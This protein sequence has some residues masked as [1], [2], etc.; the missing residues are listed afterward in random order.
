MIGVSFDVSK[1]EGKNF[2]SVRMK[3]LLYQPGE[4]LVLPNADDSDENEPG[5]VKDVGD[6]RI[7]VSLQQVNAPRD[8]EEDGHSEEDDGEEVSK[9]V[10]YGTHHQ[11]HLSVCQS[12]Q[13]QNLQHVTEADD[14]RPGGAC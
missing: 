4:Q 11:S 10:V 7:G 5:R 12:V 13:L 3:P 1:V 2:I 9:L 6:V 8:D 14:G